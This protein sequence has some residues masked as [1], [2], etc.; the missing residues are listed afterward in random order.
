MVDD[1]VGATDPQVR[2]LLAGERGVGLVFGGR[3]R[4]DCNGNIV[5]PGL[6]AQLVVAGTNRG[7]GIRRRAGI[8]HQLAALTRCS[9]ECVHVADI[10]VGEE[11]LEG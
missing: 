3:T 5:D 2:V 1:V 9:R 10:E 6:L 11:G 8:E 4:A 7:F